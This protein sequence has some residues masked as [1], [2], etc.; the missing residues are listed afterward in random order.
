MKNDAGFSQSAITD[1]SGAFTVSNLPPG[2]Y[3]LTVE[4]SGFGPL[5]RE[6]VQISAGQP[7]KLSLGL[8]AGTNSATVEVA[9][10]TSMVQDQNAEVLALL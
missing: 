3:T 1:G 7:L 9:G 5:T 4:V 2:T 6:N 8:E 10:S